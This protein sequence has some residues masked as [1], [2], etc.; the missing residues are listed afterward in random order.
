MLYNEHYILPT[1]LVYTYL[2]GH[3]GR[4]TNSEGAFRAL[5]RGYAHWASGRLARIEVNVNNPEYC[6]VRATI[7]AS[8]KP[9]SY[10]VCILLKQNGPLTSIIEATCQCAAG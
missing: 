8:M 3:V 1:G 7:K 9:V 4:R 10:N 5:K 6:H 2:A